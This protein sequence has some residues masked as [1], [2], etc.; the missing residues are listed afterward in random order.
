MKN[1]QRCPYAILLNLYIKQFKIINLLTIFSNA[2]REKSKLEIII[3]YKYIFSFFEWDNKLFFFYQNERKINLKYIRT[4]IHNI[5]PSVKQQANP[6]MKEVWSF[7][8]KPVIKPIFALIIWLTRRL[9]MHTAKE[10]ISW[11]NNI[12][13]W[14][15]KVQHIP[16]KRFQSFLD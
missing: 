15:W 8:S 5:W 9:E 3:V 2:F 6:S 12:C 10:V 11:R 14:H 7:R 4:R 16:V 1:S 13:W